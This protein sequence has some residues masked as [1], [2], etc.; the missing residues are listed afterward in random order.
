MHHKKITLQTSGNAGADGYGVFLTFP[1]RSVNYNGFNISY[2][3]FQI[4][5]TRDPTICMLYFYMSSATV[6][7]EVSIF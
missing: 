3:S 1:L 6:N 2:S 4:F 7:F 5:E